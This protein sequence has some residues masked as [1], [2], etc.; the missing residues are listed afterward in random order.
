MIE[1]LQTE[2]KSHI[3]TTDGPSFNSIAFVFKQVISM[4]FSDI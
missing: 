3:N 2:H 4:P 1:R